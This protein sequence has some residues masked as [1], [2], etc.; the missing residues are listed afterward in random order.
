MVK[1]GSCQH[2]WD[3]LLRSRTKPQS[4]LVWPVA[5]TLL[6]Q[7]KAP[8]FISDGMKTNGVMCRS[9]LLTCP[10]AGVQVLRPETLEGG[11]EGPCGSLQAEAF[12]VGDGDGQFSFEFP[13]A[14]IGRQT[15]LVEA[16][17][18]NR[19]PVRTQRR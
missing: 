9:P 13:P 17:V 14:P 16:R 11:L 12:G 10:P 1:K 19:Q 18:G 8:L 7:V 2:G 3:L 15:D 4:L 5:S 6:F